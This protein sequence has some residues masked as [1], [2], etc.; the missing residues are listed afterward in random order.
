MAFVNYF[1]HLELPYFLSK[2]FCNE[3][4]FSGE[5]SLLVNQQFMCHPVFLSQYLTWPSPDLSF[6]TEA[7]LLLSKM[8]SLLYDCQEASHTCPLDGHF[9]NGPPQLVTRTQYQELL[10]E[11]PCVPHLLC[12]GGPHRSQHSQEKLD[13]SLIKRLPDLFFFPQLPAEPI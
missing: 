13:D 4:Q 3:S 11:S 9:S 10:L 12:K 7:S 2:L 1:L 5:R 8:L 6:A